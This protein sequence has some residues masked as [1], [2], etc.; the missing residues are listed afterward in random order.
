[1]DLNVVSLKKFM[2]LLICLD[3]PVYNNIEDLI[4]L[5]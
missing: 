1:M 5:V 2:L 4:L 3:T